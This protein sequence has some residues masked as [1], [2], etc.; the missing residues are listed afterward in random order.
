[1][2]GLGL[3]LPEVAAR[4]RGF[5]P[6]MLFAG[7]ED[8]AWYDPSDP[9]T[10][11]QDEAGT[12][13]AAVDAPVGL[14]RDKS[15]RGHHALQAA[16]A[17]RPMLRRDEGGRL[18]LAFDGIDD[19]L[20]HDLAIVG[21]DVSLS[22]AAE[23]T[24]GAAVQGLFM[25]T[26]ASTR[27]RAGLMANAV[28]PDWGNFVAG[29]FQSAGADLS[30]R[31]V[32]ANIGRAAPDTQTFHTNGA[33]ARTFAGSYAGDNQDRRAIGCEFSTVADRFFTGRLHAL[34]AI[35]RAIGA[36]ELAR[37]TAW[38]AAKGGIEW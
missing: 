37:L 18:C 20:V 9:S 21:K 1:M 14:M 2:L 15:G 32:I 36:D 24:G 31:A 4:A 17:S 5:S 19:V 11:F 12:I 30:V 7:G 38:Q 35:D 26:P 10:L 29:T 22:A 25:V 16:A 23:R 3:S 34:F 8:G 27:L 6:D 28:N 13:P 33:M